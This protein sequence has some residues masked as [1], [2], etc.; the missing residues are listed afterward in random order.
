ME[1]D[2]VFIRSQRTAPEAELLKSFGLTEASPNTHLGQGT[3]NRRFFFK[4]CF[5]ELLFLENAEDAQ[6]QTTKPTQLFE[7]LSHHDSDVSPFGLCFRAKSTMQTAAPFLSWQYHPAYLPLH[8]HVD[9]AKH[10][11]LI[12]PMWFYL[13]FATRPDQASPEKQQPFQHRN[14]LSEITKIKLHIPKLSKNLTV[15]EVQYIENLELIDSENHLLEIVFDHQ[16]Q[17]KMHDFRPDLPL[18]FHY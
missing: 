11:S 3:A 5:L 15:S 12:E 10:L 13:S 9:I 16:K 18:I 17:N 6:S 14:N 1:I 8:L 7:R 4:N 2:H